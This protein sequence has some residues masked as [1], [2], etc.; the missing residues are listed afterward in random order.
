MKIGWCESLQN[1][2]LLREIGYDFVELP[3]AP[4]GLEARDTFEAAKREVQSSSL[5]P[6][7]FNVFFPRDIRVVGPEVDVDRVHNYLARAAE[8]LATAK[9]QVVVLGSGWARNVPDG[10]ERSRA[11][12]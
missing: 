10:W 3:L 11:E 5:P 8:L 9:A 7:A 2:S 1:A 12:G 6:L 4:M